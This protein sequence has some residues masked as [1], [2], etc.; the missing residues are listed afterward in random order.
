MTVLH[1]LLQL[2]QPGNLGLV[3]IDRELNQRRNLFVR[4]VHVFPECFVEASWGLEEGGFEIGALQ[5]SRRDGGLMAIGV[6]FVGQGIDPLGFAAPVRLALLVAT[7][8]ALYGALLWIMEREAIAEVMRL[9]LRRPAAE[10]VPANQD[11]I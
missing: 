5:L 10:P 1:G 4:G 3:S 6:L 2:G 8:A 9:V 7:G 11:A